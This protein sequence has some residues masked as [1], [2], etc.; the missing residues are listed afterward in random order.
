MSGDMMQR[1]VS[2][3]AG[4]SPMLVADVGCGGYAKPLQADC[5]RHVNHGCVV[6]YGAAHAAVGGTRVAANVIRTWKFPECVGGP[7]T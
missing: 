6:W 2:T 7:L 1:G 3:W 5:K 4:R